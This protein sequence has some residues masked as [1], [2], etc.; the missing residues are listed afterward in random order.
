MPLSAHVPD[1]AALEMLLTVA[2]TG[3]LNRA[4]GELGV[5]QQAVSARIRAMEAQTGVT[6]LSRSAR[7][8]SLTAE[9]VV[10]AE[11][12]ARLLDVAAEL[13][14]GLS[15]L[16]QDR[17]SHLRVS[18]SL[19][20]AELL[21]PAW[22]VSFRA[23]AQRRGEPAAQIVLTAANSDAVLEHVRD[24]SADVG[25]IEGPRA[26]RT[27]RSKVIGHDRLIVV[28]PPGHP[29]AR[30]GRV[31]PAELAAAPLV[32]REAGSG[33]RDA[34]TTALTRS[35]GPGM[36]QAPPALSLST[37]SAVRAAVLAGAA[38]AAMSHLA[39]SED[40]AAG[41]LVPVRV[42]GLDLRRTLRA[43][44]AGSAAPP[45]GPARDLIAHILGRGGSA[46]RPAGQGT[47]PG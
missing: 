9:G 10:I 32:S 22:L 46:A 41:R 36:V 16:R 7:G 21:L 24:G 45:A 47:G 1:L 18:A 29:W 39:V 30:R 34:L 19:T 26:P 44:W 6:L 43:V 12:A 37:A 2:R 5:S 40:L 3:S 27:L 15:A 13:D 14:A 11:W 23:A 28:V 8:S 33:T 31:T 35:L 25:F 38:P 17:R 4:A 20:V 42:D